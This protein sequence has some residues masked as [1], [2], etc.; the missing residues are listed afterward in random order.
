MKDLIDKLSSYNLFNYL[1]PGVVFVVL[2][3]TLTNYSFVQKDIVIGIFSY[4]FIGLVISRF[5]SLV[6]EPSLK[7]ISFLKFADYSDFITASKEDE[8]IDLFS[9]INNTYRTLCSCFTLLIVLKIVESLSNRFQF[10][11]E[12]TAFSLV[13]ILLVVFLFAY[14]K[15]TDYT[16]KRVEAKVKK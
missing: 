8:K 11:K 12:W 6:V 3:E 15:Q 9:E 4:Y 10:I 7:K 1:M 13:L 14:K 5:G 16:R 2:A